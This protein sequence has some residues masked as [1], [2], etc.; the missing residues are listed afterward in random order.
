MKSTRIMVA[1]MALASGLMFLHPSVQ[2]AQS[3]SLRPIAA[4]GP[5][6]LVSDESAKLFDIKFSHN[7]S[8]GEVDAL[9]QRTGIKPVELSY[10][11]PS[12][13][14]GAISGGYLIRQG[15]DVETALRDMLDKHITFLKEALASIKEESAAGDNPTLATNLKNL[16][17]DFRTLLADAQRG[18]FSLS[19]LKVTGGSEI[20]ALKMMTHIES[21]SPVS[22]P[23]PTRPQTEL[24]QSLFVP[25]SYY[26]ESWAPYRGTSKVTQG[27][28][29]QTFYFNKVSAF[30]STSTYEHETQIY[31]KA[32]ANYDRY[33]SSNL[34]NAYFDTPFLDKIDNFTVGTS[35][36][37][38]LENFKQYYTHVALR[39]GSARSAKVRIK[40]QLGRRDPTWCDSPWCVWAR[41]T[42]SSLVTFTAPR[43]G[44]LSYSY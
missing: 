36:A 38:K 18:K 16:T 39:K 8:P 20:L 35:R 22:L 27:Q 43:T 11:F 10:E 41:S 34:P 21:V 1:L 31:D 2:L 23:T 25:A 44:T 4:T 14:G 33:W 15:E 13:Q 5:Q 6:T 26:H 40:G 9:V 17:K 28:S 37:S 42:T 3:Q 32:F 12:R 19:G 30:G 24:M 7:V 29:F